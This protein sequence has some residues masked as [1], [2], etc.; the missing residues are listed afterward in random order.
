[1]GIAYLC[2]IDEADEANIALDEDYGEWEWVEREK[3]QEYI[4]NKYVMDDLEGV[5]L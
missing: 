2:N 4:D 1:M 5:V 3:F